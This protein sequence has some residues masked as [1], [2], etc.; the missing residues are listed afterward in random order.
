MAAAP[1]K[2]EELSVADARSPRHAM[3]DSAPMAANSTTTIGR[4][5]D[6]RN[7]ELRRVSEVRD[8][9]SVCALYLVHTVFDDDSVY[10]ECSVFTA[11]R[12]VPQAKVAP[13]AAL[14]R[15][16]MTP[17]LRGVQLVSR[18]RRH[19]HPLQTPTR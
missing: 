3:A 10:G 7:R 15:W 18:F 19:P 8:E 6:A 5:D 9:F 2:G 17:D 14:Q 4:R 13:D 1:V 16:C 12:N 11:F